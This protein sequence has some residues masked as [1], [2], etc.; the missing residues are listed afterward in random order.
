MSAAEGAAPAIVTDH[1]FEPRVQ[2]IDGLAPNE[3]LCQ[4]CG[5]AES[6]HAMA[7]GMLALPKAY[8]CPTCVE[9]GAELCAHGAP[10]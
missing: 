5:L 3:Y 1:R 8:R 2:E 7:R 4:D 9:A 6:A 10:R